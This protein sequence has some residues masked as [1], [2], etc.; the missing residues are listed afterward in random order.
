MATKTDLLPFGGLPFPWRNMVYPSCMTLPFVVSHFQRLVRHAGLPAAAIFL[1]PQR[2]DPAGA[3]ASAETGKGQR[4]EPHVLA[5]SDELPKTFLVGEGIAG[6]SGTGAANPA[7]A[8]VLG[9]L[10][11]ANQ[12]GVAHLGRKESR[13]KRRQS[14]RLIS[15]SPKASHLC[16]FLNM[17]ASLNLTP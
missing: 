5:G 16:S 3:G 6:A 4:A 7:H 2:L 11:L 8:T 9:F 10:L 14:E 12:L 1:L 13:A 15:S 17:P